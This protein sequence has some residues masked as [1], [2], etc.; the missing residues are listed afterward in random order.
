M[1]GADRNERIR[2]VAVLEATCDYLE[3]QIPGF[4]P[5]ERGLWTRA[6]LRLRKLKIELAAELKDQPEEEPPW[7]NRIA[8]YG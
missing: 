1:S 5:G 7:P 6:V 2:D 8:G 3:R 4:D